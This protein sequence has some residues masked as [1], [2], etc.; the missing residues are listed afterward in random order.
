MASGT[1][2]KPMEDIEIGT[3]STNGANRTIVL[4]GNYS[5]MRAFVATVIS[6]DYQASFNILSSITFTTPN[7]VSFQIK[8]EG[9]G[10]AASGN[11]N[12]SYVFSGI[13]A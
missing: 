6:G 9:D 4:K 8:R 2:R 12:V 10:S 5:S 7:K 3:A 1:I 13:K 11:Y